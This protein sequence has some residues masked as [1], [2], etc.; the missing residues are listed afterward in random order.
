MRSSCIA[1]RRAGVRDE[2]D[3]GEEKRDEEEEAMGLG[4]SVVD[5]ARKRRSGLREDTLD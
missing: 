2:R 3:L 1:Q 5:E 4:A